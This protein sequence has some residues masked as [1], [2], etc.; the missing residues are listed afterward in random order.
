MSAVK[1]RRVQ[2]PR[3][4]AIKKVSPAKESAPT[5]ENQPQTPSEKTPDD[6]ITA[7]PK[8]DVY[9][10]DIISSSNIANNLAMDESALMVDK[11]L[12]SER[13]VPKQAVAS[14]P[15]PEEP[16][17]EPMAA[18]ATEV[19]SPPAAGSPNVAGQQEAVDVVGLEFPVQM[20]PVSLFP[21]GSPQGR[22]SVY[23]N[24][25]KSVE[26]TSLILDMDTRENIVSAKAKTPLSEAVVLA[27]QT[28]GIAMTGQPQTTSQYFSTF[29]EMVPSVQ[30]VCS[31]ADSYSMSP[32]SA[33][34]S[35]GPQQCR[36]SPAGVGFQPYVTSTLPPEQMYNSPTSNCPPCNSD[37]TKITKCLPPY[38][39]IPNILDQFA[40]NNSYLP[41]GREICFDINFPPNM[42]PKIVNINREGMRLAF[43]NNVDACGR[44]IGT[45]VTSMPMIV[46]QRPPQEET[47]SSSEYDIQSDSYDNMMSCISCAKKTIQLKMKTGASIPNVLETF[48]KYDYKIAPLFFHVIQEVLPLEEFATVRSR[49]SATSDPFLLFDTTDHER[50]IATPCFTINPHPSRE[51][52]FAVYSQGIFPHLCMKVGKAL[53]R[54][55][56]LHHVKNG[57]KILP[58]FKMPDTPNLIR[59]LVYSFSN[60]LFFEFPQNEFWTEQNVSMCLRQSTP[61][62]F[63]YVFATLA[64]MQDVKIHGDYVIQLVYLNRSL[65]EKQPG[66]LDRTKPREARL[67]HYDTNESTR[68]MPMK[69]RSEMTNAYVYSMI[70]KLKK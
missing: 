55:S 22:K 4:V 70:K 26:S 9:P 24:D 31:A 13:G 56:E 38:K 17:D 28:T 32:C 69:K 37:L 67:L 66:V 62:E 65:S 19:M 36:S 23:E 41:L 49:M 52:F 53:L 30:A 43:V 54:I 7:S 11:S 21:R 42:K 57:I 14:P 34:P 40:Q 48:L 27:P 46:Q 3:K 68:F 64:A 18:P 39:T 59:V 47:V 35:T 29:S 6:D 10:V 15:M 60:D 51:Y 61:Q 50:V 63:R 20:S 1:K 2:K 12:A 58:R 8:E 33:V 45:D 5:E 25:I 44:N 16:N